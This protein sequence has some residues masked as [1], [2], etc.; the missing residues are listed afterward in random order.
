MEI[1]VAVDVLQM[2]DKIMIIAG[3]RVRI[4]YANILYDQ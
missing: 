1:G 2:W 4:P 3:Y